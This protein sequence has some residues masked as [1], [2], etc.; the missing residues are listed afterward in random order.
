MLGYFATLATHAAFV[1]TIIVLIYTTSLTTVE[2]EFAR[3]ILTG[4]LEIMKC[5]EDLSAFSALFL[6][7]FTLY[8]GKNSL[9][10]KF[11]I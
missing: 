8:E 4:I 10:L 3:V 2:L 9:I 1:A 5:N 7:D 6:L 11:L